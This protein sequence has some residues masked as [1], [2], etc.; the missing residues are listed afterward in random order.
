[1]AQIAGSFKPCAGRRSAVTERLAELRK[2]LAAVVAEP[3]LE[4]FPAS[5]DASFRRYFRVQTAD[6]SRVVMDAPPDRESVQRYVLVARVLSRAGVHV[7]QILASDPERGF[8]L[9]GDLG[10]RTYLQALE[11]G[12]PPDP[13]YTDALAALLRIQR[14]AEPDALPP[15]DRALLERELA[16][17]REW[18]LERHLGLRI[19]AAMAADL[20][21]VDAFLVHA[22]LAQPRTVVHRDYH[23][24]N[25]M[26]T[27]PNPGVLDFQDAVVG[28]I[29]Y[30][31]V[32]LLR[33]CYV[34]W[35]A[36]QVTEWLQAYHG[37]AAAAGLPVGALATFRRAFD[38]AGV[39]RHL[40][41][42]G[43]FARL[44]HRDGKAGYLG[45]IPRVLSYVQAV[46]P[47][48]RELDAL[49]RLMEREVL[50]RMTG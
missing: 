42:I 12:Q 18:F 40:K 22:A 10:D 49:R 39:Q 31:L 27:E 32:S 14:H 46:A 35:P 15:Y 4:L 1:M 7:P 24:R 8:L 34:A 17:F 6:G 38:L 9:L 25:L 41:A 37:R 11:H 19:D 33:D 20:V 43:I 44:W 30:D 29:A 23:S 50:P 13:L 3:D 5:S 36:E 26:V 21:A 45:D 47:P 48:Y 2:W 28:P 16:I